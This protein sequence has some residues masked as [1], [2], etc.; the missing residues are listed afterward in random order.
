MVRNRQTKWQETVQKRSK[1]SIMTGK[2][3]SKVM[4]T[5]SKSTQDASRQTH[6]LHTFSQ[7]ETSILTVFFKENQCFIGEKGHIF[8]QFCIFFRHF[9]HIF[10]YFC[11]TLPRFAQFRFKTTET[12]PPPPKNNDRKTPENGQKMVPKWYRNGPK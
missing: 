2:N 12:P 3:G 1:G 4:Y 8:G 9:W 10:A 11:L 6:S 5:Y 7:V